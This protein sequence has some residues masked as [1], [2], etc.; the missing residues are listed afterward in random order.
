[1][2]PPAIDGQITFVYTPNLDASAQF[3]EQIMG[4]DI[5]LDQGSCR[6][7]QVASDSYIGI[8]QANSSPSGKAVD[9]PPANVILTLVTQQVDEWYD[10]LNSR[11][12]A[13]EKTPEYNHKYDI[14]H[15][16]LR[17][18]GG[19]LIEIQRFGT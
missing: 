6:I 12:I 16:F 8:C 9:L 15:C 18:P 11:G 13:F 5:W 14:Y 2:K 3:Y 19:Y 4:F 10:Y 7:Y 1:M 17:D